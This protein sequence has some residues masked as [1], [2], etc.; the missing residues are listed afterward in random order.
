[1]IEELVVPWRTYTRAVM[2]LKRPNELLPIQF[3]RM[4]EAFDIIEVNDEPGT[5]DFRIKFGSK[6]S[7]VLFILKWS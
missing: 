7:A 1:M 5:P 6:E 2:A 3:A 4:T